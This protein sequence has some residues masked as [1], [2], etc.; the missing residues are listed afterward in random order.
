MK[1]LTFV[2]ATFI[3]F[4][5]FNFYGCEKKADASL[6]YEIFCELQDNLLEG[7]ERVNYLNEGENVER[8]LMFNLHVNA[9]REGAKY[10]AIQKNSTHYAYYKGE[11]FG[12]I[13]IKGVTN[14]KNESLDYEILGEDE[15]ILRVNLKN[16]LYPNERCV[17]V[18]DYVIN[19]PYVIARTGITE[20][21]INLASFYPILCAKMD[22]E[23]Y[24]CVY[25]STGDPFYSDVA[26]YK[27]EITLDKE[28]VVASSGELLSSKE[29]GEK[30]TNCYQ[31]KNARNFCFVLSKDYSVITDTVDGVTVN[32]YYYSDEKNQE[33]LS[34]AVEALKLFSKKFCDYP[35]KTYSVCQTEFLEGGMEFC[36]L[37][38]ISDTLEDGAYK[39]V[40]VHETAHQW[41]H[42]IVGNNEIEY[43]FLDEGL[44]EYSVV[45]FYENNSQY[46]FTREGL[47]NSAEKTYKTFCTVQDRLFN[48]VDTSMVRSLKDFTS[49]FEYVC[50]SYVKG[51]IMH[52]YVRKSVG[53]ELYF[54]GLKR[55]IEDNKFCNATPENLVG[56][57][58][59]VGADTNG[60]FK[61]FFDGSVII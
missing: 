9:F 60:V 54:K 29:R 7:K 50:V 43:G 15:N 51:A 2:L 6:S 14:D 20:K 49:E 48:K 17:V 38:M 36:A 33:N 26:N 16:E 39:E 57:F 18:I 52:D 59:K 53:D 11:N 21:G 30:K 5:S 4:I 47:I 37:S 34:L 13:E 46:G 23:F 55:Y 10:P 8:F 41:W 42:A 35:Y 28:I 61:S 45:M 27:V 31:I 3:F 12:G 40:I 19:L 44:A 25:Y 58:E 1:K 24:E 22:G 56:S 32:Y